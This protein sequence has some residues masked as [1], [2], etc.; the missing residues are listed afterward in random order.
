[1][2]EARKLAGFRLPLSLIEKI[3]IAAMAAGTSVNEY[4]CSILSVA[5][6]NIET[7][8]EKEERIRETQSFLDCFSGAWASSG[9]DEDLNAVIQNNKSISSPV[10]L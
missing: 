6:E 1:M 2:K 4:V 5:T 3:K 10:E 8:E 9:K 7:Q